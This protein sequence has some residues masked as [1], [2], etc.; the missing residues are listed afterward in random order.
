MTLDL[1]RAT[2]D[3]A[4]FVWEVNNHPLVRAK[5]VSTSTISW[6]D[7]ERWF[8]RKLADPSVLF[9]IGI[10]D[11]EPVAVVRFEIA[12]GEAT[13][14]VA[15]DPSYHGRGVGTALIARATA[16]LVG[17]GDVVRAVAWIR[18]DNLAS[19][20]AFAHAGY[21]RVGTGEKA[22]VDLERFEFAVA[23]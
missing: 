22:G 12:H 18:P 4:R 21:M 1:R 7:H 5:S 16:E 20:K 14:G 3:D 23:R 9:F 2:Y 6:A 19:L 8:E 17:R 11:G 13:I 15:V 10:R